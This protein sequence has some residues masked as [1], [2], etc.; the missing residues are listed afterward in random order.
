MMV[1]D[2]LSN[3]MGMLNPTFQAPKL[4]SLEAHI[5]LV[6]SI[7]TVVFCHWILSRSTKSGWLV[8]L[9]LSM[10]LCL[11]IFLLL[12]ILD[13]LAAF[14]LTAALVFLEAVLEN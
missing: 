3:I 5:A 6:Y 8:V 4:V 11:S 9:C 7:P 10:F 2:V 14:T 13:C 1:I 12:F